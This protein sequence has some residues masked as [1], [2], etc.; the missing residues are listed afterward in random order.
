V[1]RVFRDIESKR[2]TTQYLHLPPLPAVPVP[3]ITAC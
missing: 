1:A 2:R 3:E